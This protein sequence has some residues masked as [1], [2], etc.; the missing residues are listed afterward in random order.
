MREAPLEAYTSP[1]LKFGRILAL[2]RLDRLNE[3]G[4]ELQQANASYPK[5]LKWLLPAKVI[6]PDDPDDDDDFTHENT[7]EEV[8]WCSRLEMRDEWVGATGA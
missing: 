2:Y 3:A 7:D 4:Q 8:A 6:D 5:M 1:H